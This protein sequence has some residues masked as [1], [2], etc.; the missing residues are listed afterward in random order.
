MIWGH[1]R[2]LVLCAL[3]C[4]IT[5][6]CVCTSACS[7]QILLRTPSFWEQKASHTNISLEMAMFS[8]GVLIPSS[9]SPF[10]KA[11]QVSCLKL[12]S[13]DVII[14]LLQQISGLL[15]GCNWSS[16][17]SASS[18]NSVLLNIS[19]ALSSGSPALHCLRNAALGLGSYPMPSTAPVC[20][21][22]PSFL[23]GFCRICFP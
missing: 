3:G 11:G 5:C 13:G 22:T 7:S 16:I 18:P 8:M 12:V 10:I 17:N 21:I 2:S 4:T 1:D 14:L 6:V 15:G 23:E 9:S 19:Q 20:T